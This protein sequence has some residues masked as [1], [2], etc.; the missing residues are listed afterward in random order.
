VKMEKQP[1]NFD[2]LIHRMNRAYGCFMIWKFLR[3]SISI[4]EVGQ[5]EANRRLAIMNHYDGIFSGILYATENTFITDL[6]KFFDRTKG[7][8][9]LHSLIKKLS[10]SKNKEVCL[11]LASL[12]LEIK[13]I[14]NLRHN[15]TSHEPVIPKEEKIF[16]EEVERLF[17]VIPQILNIISESMGREHMIWDMWEETNNKAFKRLL[18]DLGKGILN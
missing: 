17:S 13:R 14:K 15:F 7:S 4:P 16:I 12:E 1:D 2:R 11:L 9:T 10:V 5:E 3:K 6:H 18:N 8:L